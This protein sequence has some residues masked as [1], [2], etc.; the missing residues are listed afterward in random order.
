MPD[1]AIDVLDASGNFTGRVK[2]KSDVHRDGDW[3]RSVHV[4]IVTPDGRLLL[5]KRA[6]TKQSH[7]NLWDVSAAGHISAGES[8]VVSA[9]REIEEELGLSVAPQELR[10]VAQSRIEWSLNEGRFLENEFHDIYMVRR[11]VDVAS[12][13]LQASEVDDAR[14][15]TMDELRVLVGS[16]DASMVPHWREYDLVLRLLSN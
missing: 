15:V 11:D 10:L 3:H 7:P 4:W 5:Q 9:V 13:H 14:L 16:R 8:S 1:E 12:L 6:S 2:L